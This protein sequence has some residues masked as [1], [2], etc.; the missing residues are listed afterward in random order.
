MILLFGFGF[1]FNFLFFVQTGNPI[2]ETFNLLFVQVVRHPEFFVA[3]LNRCRGVSRVAANFAV[4]RILRD[5]LEERVSDIERLFRIVCA[6]EHFHNVSGD[7]AVGEGFSEEF[8]DL[9]AR[10]FFLELARVDYV[11][12][13]LFTDDWRSFDLRSSFGGLNEIDFAR[14]RFAR[15]GFVR[16]FRGLGRFALNFALSRCRGRYFF[17]LRY[18]YQFLSLCKRFY[19]SYGLILTHKDGNWTENRSFLLE[20]G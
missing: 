3:D 10:R 6:K 16:R 11:A 7:F 12:H 2:L 14:C 20:L 13:N 18:F 4:V 17:C 9:C 19:L 8:A 5:G 15:R 1:G